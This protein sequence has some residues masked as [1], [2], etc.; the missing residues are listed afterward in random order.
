MDLKFLEEQREEK[1]EAM[2]K[3]I[4]KAKEEERALTEEETTSFDELEAEIKGLDSSIEKFN[5][6]RD[7]LKE[8]KP[9]V[10]EKEEGEKEKMDEEKRALEKR[11]LEEFGKLIKNE[12]VEMRAEAGYS[13][14]SNGTIIPTTIANDIVK[15]AFDMSPILDKA[16]VFHVKGKLSLPY[17]DTAE[18]DLT[19][20]YANE[21]EELTEKAG[22]F[23]TIDLEGFLIGVLTKL[24]KTLLN[25]TDLE[26]ADFVIKLLQD[27]VRRFVE[28]EVI[29]GTAKIKALTEVDNLLEAKEVNLDTLIKL[30]NQVK[31]VY[32]KGSIWVMNNETLTAIEL[33]KDNNG[34]PILNIDP[35]GEYNGMI[36]GYPVYVSD[37]MDGVVNGK[38]AIYFGNFEHLVINTPQELEIQVL[39]EKY[40]TQNAIGIV[41]WL[42]LDAKVQNKEAIAAFKVNTAK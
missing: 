11:E 37:N 12:L 8:E 9:E 38:N 15:K 41:G 27:Y 23:K 10:E 39:Q 21:F 26:V 16:K 2:E 19:V 20:N 35:T 1:K 24:S 7:L 42:E 6:A 13:K 28:K 30:K 22:K 5:R 4:N 31:Q 25:N 34:R 32:R 33:L 3:I 17:Y 29:T 36:L 40:A 18:S 14:G